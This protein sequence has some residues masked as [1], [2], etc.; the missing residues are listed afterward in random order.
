MMV[1]SGKAV[2]LA[3]CLFAAVEVKAMR[4]G[5]EWR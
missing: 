3:A 1:E 2:E 5:K 4:S